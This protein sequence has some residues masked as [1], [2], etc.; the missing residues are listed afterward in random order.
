MGSDLSSRAAIHDLVVDF[1]REVVFDDL[2]GP[3]FGE[4]AEVDW[5]IHIPK[6]VDYWS[7]ILLDEPGPATSIV[8]VHRALHQSEPMTSEHCDRW[9]GLWCASIDSRWSGPYADRARRH[10]AALMSGMAKHVFGF[11]WEPSDGGDTALPSALDGIGL[12]IRPRRD[13]VGTAARSAPGVDPG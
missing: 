3:V 13:R 11:A 12:A 9:W 4:V 7:R 6:L 2:L 1:Y 10:A 8:G 5:S